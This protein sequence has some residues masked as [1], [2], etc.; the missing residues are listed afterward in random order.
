MYTYSPEQATAIN[1][2]GY[3]HSFS[4]LFYHEEDPDGKKVYV[5]YENWFYPNLGT[6]L[7]FENG[8]LV[9]E[10]G[11]DPYAAVPTRYKPAMFT[12]FMN[13]EALATAAEIDKWLILPV[14]EELLYDADHYYAEGLTFG[15]QSDEL[16]FIEAVGLEDR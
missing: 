10:E 15:L 7:T 6:S 9:K 14:E 4:I 12:A 5:R 11:M 3:P 2:K 8:L 16:V 13:R 1:E